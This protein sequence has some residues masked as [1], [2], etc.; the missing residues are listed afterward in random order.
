MKTKFFEF[1]FNFTI[2]IIG[3]AIF[4]SAIFFFL[5]KCDQRNAYIDRGPGYVTVGP[6]HRFGYNNKIYSILDYLYY[7]HI[8]I[9]NFLIG[10]DFPVDL[11]CMK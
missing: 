3:I 2:I 8:M 7:P 9:F 4:Y 11:D 10:N 5:Y 1:N 6:A